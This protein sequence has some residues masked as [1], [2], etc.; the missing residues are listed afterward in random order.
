MPR[1][2][3]GTDG[4]RGIV[5]ETLTLELVER[6]GRAATVVGRPRPGLRRPRHARLRAGARGSASCG[7]SPRP[8][9]SP[10]S[11]VCCR[12]PRSHCW[13]RISGSS[14][15]RRTT[16]PSTTGS[17]SS[18]PK[19]TSCRTPRRRRSR[20]CSTPR[21]PTV[22]RSSRGGCRRGRL[23]RARR[24]ALRLSPRRPPDRGRLRE[25]RLLRDRARVS[26]SASARRSRPSPPHPTGRTS[27]SAAAQPTCGLLQEVV[28]AG[29][30]D[31]GVAFDGDG[32]RMLA[33]DETGARSG[34]RSDPRRA[35]AR[36]GR[37]HRRGDDDDATSASTG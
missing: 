11:A 31:L 10:S 23:R 2:H 16:R 33:V 28:R 30:H 1:T 9:G 7:G 19:A 15:R 24:R 5:G 18:T 37:R 13:R 8:A 29:G 20:P 14:S 22:A 3:F 36:S 6:L 32:D 25:R 17:S 27:T 26:S 12:L 34:R 21:P 4:V 35:R